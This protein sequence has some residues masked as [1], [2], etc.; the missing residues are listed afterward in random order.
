MKINE[1]AAIWDRVKVS[2]GAASRLQM[3]ANFGSLK[4][5][6]IHEIMK[7][8][9]IIGNP[10]NVW[11]SSQLRSS[12]GVFMGSISFAKAGKL[13]T[14]E[15]HANPWNLIKS[16]DINENHETAASW[17][18]VKLSLGSASRLQRPANFGPLKK[19]KSMKSHEI[20]RNLWKS[21]KEQPGRIE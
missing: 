19:W 15:T 6:E 3:P 17:H 21:I 14:P 7:S 12:R 20:S 8:H 2:L 1:I 5:V 18:G 9:V 10:W 16:S 11:N 13:W 4:S